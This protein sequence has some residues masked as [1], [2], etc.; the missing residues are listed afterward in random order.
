ME[1]CE[2]V[3][4]PL[5]VALLLAPLAVIAC[6]A[7][8]EGVVPQNGL[9]ELGKGDA[10]LID[11]LK[12]VGEHQLVVFHED[13]AGHEVPGPGVAELPAAATLCRVE[14]DNDGV[15]EK[16]EARDG[17]TPGEKVDLPK[18]L[19]RP[20]GGQRL[21][22]RGRAEQVACQTMRAC[23]PGPSMT[24]SVYRVRAGTASLS[25]GDHAHRLRAEVRGHELHLGRLQSANSLRM[26]GYLLVHEHASLTGEARAAW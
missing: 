24:S 10:D 6:Q 4:G 12:V 5:G 3:T 11:A 8:V 25:A 18:K 9:V 16:H 13:L 15:K 2:I 7:D 20:K 17:F 21:L 26:L 1:A 14:K 19:Q 22:S 23:W